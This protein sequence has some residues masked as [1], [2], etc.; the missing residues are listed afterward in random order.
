MSVPGE[1]AVAI[2]TDAIQMTSQLDSPSGVGSR[3]FTQPL[4]APGSPSSFPPLPP[5]LFGGAG[6]QTGGGVKTQF[7]ALAFNPWDTGSAGG[8]GGGPTAP[9]AALTR[10]AFAD[11][12]GGEIAVSGLPQPLR[13][14]MPTAPNMTQ[15]FG[16]V[17]SFWDAAAAA[18]QTEGC[19]A[20]PSPFPANH[21]VRWSLPPPPPPPPLLRGPPPPD[22]GAMAPLLPW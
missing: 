18:F 15:G 13:F 4:S 16:A 5:S 10:L 14:I 21:S 7:V 11:L 2:G 12:S 1:D 9:S 3:L 19:A 22:E 17:C 6:A 8:D 20:L